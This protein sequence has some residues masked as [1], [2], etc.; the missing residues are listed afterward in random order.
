MKRYVV[1]RCIFQLVMV[2]LLLIGVAFKVEAARIALIEPSSATVG[3][4]IKVQGEGYQSTETVRIDLT[5]Q[6][7]AAKTECAEGRFSTSFVLGNFP[8]GKARFV[9][10]GFNSLSYNEGFIDVKGSL[11]P[12]VPSS[13]TVG[14]L[15]TLSGNGYEAEED[16]QVDLGDITNIA[17]QTSDKQGGFGIIF[18]IPSQTAGSKLI[19]IKG[20]KS[21]QSHQ[22]KFEVQ[23]DIKTLVPTYGMVGTDV[24]VTGAGFGSN[25]PIKIDLGSAKEIAKVK[26]DTQGNFMASF[27]LDTQPEGRKTLLVKGLLSGEKGERIFVVIPGIF[28][29]SPQSGIIGTSVTIRGNGYGVSETIRVD[30]GRTININTT[31]SDK[32]GGFESVFSLNAQPGGKARIAAVGLHSRKVSFTDVFDVLSNVMIKPESGTIG[33]MVRVEGYG[34]PLN[35]P[36]RIALGMNASETIVTTD[37]RQG[38]FGGNLVVEPHPAGIVDIRV[39]TKGGEEYKGQFKVAGKIRLVSPTAAVAGSLIEVIADGYGASEGIRVD[40]GDTQGIA[41]AQSDEKGCVKLSFN[42]DAQTGGKKTLTIVGLTSGEQDKQ[43]FTINPK[44]VISPLSGLPG[45]TIKITGS[46]YLPTELI[47][48]DCGKK[49][50]AAKAKADESGSFE[51]DLVIAKEEL[52]GVLRIV[53]IGM[54]N[55]QISSANWTVVEE[56]KIQPTLVPEEKSESQEKTKEIKE[57]EQSEV[58]E[59]SKEKA[60]GEEK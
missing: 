37:A 3:T 15:V 13:G 35:E 19:K 56:M 16:I 55:Y 58:K 1:S 40:L 8:Y 22:A 6:F 42:L 26:S 4:V 18:T 7:S 57:E 30:L 2:G 46:G 31:Q 34:F 11:N 59:G 54:T 17:T 29:V 32:N 25:E 39:I 24:I 20:L 53:G 5:G 49:I 9:V 60:E 43:E 23:G 14:T 45:I 27:K 50:D 52:P 51:L 12:I 38:I 47:R 41:L 36:I 21:N 33:S 10:I 28:F 44:L 48:I